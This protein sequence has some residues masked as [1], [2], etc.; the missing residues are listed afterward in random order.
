M[1]VNHAEKA[2]AGEGT[3]A[4]GALE[5]RKEKGNANDLSCFLQ[6]RPLVVYRLWDAAGFEPRF[7]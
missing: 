2:P 7:F 6:K 3:I 5:K 4:G 1:A